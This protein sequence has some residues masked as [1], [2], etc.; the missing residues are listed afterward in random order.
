[1]L[2]RDFLKSLLLY[3]LGTIHF[4]VSVFLFNHFL[5]LF[6]QQNGSSKLVYTRNQLVALRNNVSGVPTDIIPEELWHYGAAEPAL[7]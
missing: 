5:T 6:N 4:E 2:F 7:K 1:M 3:K